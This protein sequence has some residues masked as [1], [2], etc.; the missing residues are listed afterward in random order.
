MAARLLGL[1]EPGMPAP[2][3]NRQD[4]LESFWHVLLWTAL[5]HCDHKLSSNRIQSRLQNL[6]DS[7][8]T[9]VVSGQTE[10]GSNKKGELGSQS[11]IREMRLGNEVLEGILLD[12]ARVLD[13]RYPRTSQEEMVV[14]EV[15]KMWKVIQSENPHLPESD[16]EERLLQIVYRGD[17][18]MR[19]F[20]LW[21][22]RRIQK[23]VR[24]MENIFETALNDSTA[25]WDVGSA[26]IERCLPGKE[27]GKKRQS[28]EDSNLESNGK[29][30]RVSGMFFGTLQ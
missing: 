24:W 2:I 3:P 10:G 26:N 6:F 5:K 30:Q 21:Q 19:I 18:N 13:T 15:E 17:K 27:R 28:G 8:Y 9:D 29:R 7:S 14:T 16:L 22:D 1:P 20:S 11:V 12:V 4:D 25:A 23:D